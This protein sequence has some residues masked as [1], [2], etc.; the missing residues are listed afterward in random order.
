MVHSFINM[1]IESQ[2]GVL[3]FFL[4]PWKFHFRKLY[5]SQHFHLVLEKHIK[6][7]EEEETENLYPVYK[8]ILPLI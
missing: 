6:L 7:E 8:N 2:P 4:L 1:L 3:L 5:S